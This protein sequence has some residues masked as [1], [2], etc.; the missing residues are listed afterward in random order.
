MADGPPPRST[1][2]ASAST[3][4]PVQIV[5]AVRPSTTTDPGDLQRAGT[6]MNAKVGALDY[7]FPVGFGSSAGPSRPQ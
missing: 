7:P 5:N 6:P 3:T 1:M 4:L 2:S